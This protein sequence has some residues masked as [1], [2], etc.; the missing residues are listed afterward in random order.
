MISFK[1]PQFN[2]TIYIFLYVFQTISLH[3]IFYSRIF[4]LKHLY[5]LPNSFEF[6]PKIFSYVLA[7]KLCTIHLHG[8]HRSLFTLCI[9]LT[10]FATAAADSASH[11]V[12]LQRILG[13]V[14]H[15]AAA[16]VATI[17][18]RHI[19]Q[20]LICEIAHHGNCKETEREKE[21]ERKR[22]E[23]MSEW[24]RLHKKCNKK[25]EKGRRRD[26]VMGGHCGRNWQLPILISQAN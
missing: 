21:S 2:F 20:L 17:R 14:W 1:K 13:C 3:C 10:P 11:F 26:T 23:R 16:T 15:D 24:N 22:D 12:A 18:R 8:M 4:H 6:S 7:G 19:E 25:G 5:L 9:V